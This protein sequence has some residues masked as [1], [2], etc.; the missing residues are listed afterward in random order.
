MLQKN[1]KNEV[2][3]D[4]FQEEILK[5]LGSGKG[6]VLAIIKRQLNASSP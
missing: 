6:V 1:D 5:K 4:S 3:R 2:N